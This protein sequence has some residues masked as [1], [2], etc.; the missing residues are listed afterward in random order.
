MNSSSN[1]VAYIRVSTQ[2]Q[3]SSG[4][5]LEAQRAAV[6]AHC[7]PRG[8]TVLREFQEVE[9]GKNSNRVVLR[10]AIAFA[11]RT[12]STLLIAKLDRL[13]RNVAFIA[14]IMESDVD[15]TAC[16]LPEANRLLLHVMSAVAENEGR[17][18]S[19]RTKVA[20][21]AAKARGTL[22]GASNPKSRN[23][24]P[25]AVVRGQQ[26]GAASTKANAAAAYAEMMPMVIELRAD[27]LS[28]AE[29]AAHLTDAGFMSRTG[30]VLTAMQIKRLLDRAN[31]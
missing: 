12:K 16:D 13:A 4:L 20:L 23:L 27:G 26:R 8:L 21:A 24:T 30:K 2:K 29:V 7:K 10:D 22:L 3:G 14:N 1:V 19:E 15:F 31:R 18:I 6:A 5:G 11:R 28:Y 17:A 25:E 9:S